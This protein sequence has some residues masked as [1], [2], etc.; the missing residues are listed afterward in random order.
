MVRL[1]GTGLLMFG[2]MLFLVPGFICGAV[3]WLFS[4]VGF[5]QLLAMLLGSIGLYLILLL[6]ELFLWL[7][8][9]D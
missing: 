8:V 4:P 3:W 5:W 7:F 9:N 2:L 6:V 1:E